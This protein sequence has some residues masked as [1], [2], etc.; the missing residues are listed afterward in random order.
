MMK[1]SV[2]SGGNDEKTVVTNNIHYFTRIKMTELGAI[3]ATPSK[4]D[5]IYDAIFP[6]GF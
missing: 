2:I 3:N 5:T 4:F 1:S 6:L